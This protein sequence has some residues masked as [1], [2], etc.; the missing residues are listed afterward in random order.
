MCYHVGCATLKSA[1]IIGPL[2]R[3]YFINVW[4][5]WN[6]EFCTCLPDGIH[7]ALSKRDV[8]EHKC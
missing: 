7:M 2:G 1:T 6:Q 3:R 8:M 4:I 5:E